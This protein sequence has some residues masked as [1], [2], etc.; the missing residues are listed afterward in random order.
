[1]NERMSDAEEIGRE[2][3]CLSTF[4]PTTAD[5]RQWVDRRMSDVTDLL[6]TAYGA[7][8]NGQATHLERVHVS[9]PYVFAAT[10]GA[11]DR[12]VGCFYLHREGKH[13]AI[14]VDPLVQRRGI[15]A[16]LL[17]TSLDAAPDQW[18]E[19]AISDGRYSTLL[20]RAGFTVARTQREVLALLGP[21]LEPLICGWSSTA[22]GLTYGRTSFSGKH[23][24][25]WYRLF[26]TGCP[27]PRVA[28]D[29]RYYLAPF[30]S[31]PIVEGGQCAE[32]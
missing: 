15:G 14:G 3:V 6:G 13:G 4:V 17:Q 12:L 23:G 5:W 21:L 16:A 10:S 19:V 11:N 8:D 20:T 9:K 31:A 27:K 2:Q 26:S 29:G 22:E 7:R 24:V 28:N 30:P 1:M 32:H 18:A 25:V